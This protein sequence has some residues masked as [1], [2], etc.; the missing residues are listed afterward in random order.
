MA[1]GKRI[2]RK[3]HLGTAKKMIKKP[4]KVLLLKELCRLDEKNTSSPK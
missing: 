4:K 2:Q 1:A 3:H